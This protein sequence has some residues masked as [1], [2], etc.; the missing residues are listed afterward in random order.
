M[1]KYLTGI[2]KATTYAAILCS[3][4]AQANIINLPVDITIRDFHQ[5]HPDFQNGISGLTSGMV[6][7][8]L[9]GGV[10]VFVAAGG[11]GSVNNATT[12]ASWYSGAC[13]SST[14]SLTCVATYNEQINT[15]VDES[16]GQLTYNSSSFFPLDAITGITG[17]GDSNNNHNYFFTVQFSL[18]LVYDPNLTNTFLFTGDDDVWV[19]INDQLVL[20]LG[21]VHSAATAGFNMNAIALSQGIQAGE[22]YSFDFFFAERHFTESNVNITSFLGAPVSVPEPSSLAVFTLGLIGLAGFWRRKKA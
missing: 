15:T 20:D 7:T 22:Q 3:S 2:L 5:V 10:P 6:G 13:D 16:T 1:K 12:F 14:P 9:V 11:T 4:V 21:G 8:T 18:D 19:F 17:D